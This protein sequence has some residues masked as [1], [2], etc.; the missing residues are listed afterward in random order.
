MQKEK[1]EESEWTPGKELVHWIPDRQLPGDLLLEEFDWKDVVRLAAAFPVLWEHLEHMVEVAYR[2][3]LPDPDAI[4]NV[5][6]R[7]RVSLMT[8]VG[9][10]DRN[11]YMDVFHKCAADGDHKTAEWLADRLQITGA[12]IRILFG[13]NVFYAVCCSGNLSLVQWFADRF[14]VEY[15]DCFNKG[16]EGVRHPFALRRACEHGHIHVA[17]WLVDRFG[18][19]GTDVRSAR[20]TVA[21][22]ICENGQLEVL[23]WLI[24]R[25]DL[26]RHDVVEDN[27]TFLKACEHG[28]LRLAKWMAE[29]YNMTREEVSRYDEKPLQLACANGHTAMV[30]WLCKTYG[31]RRNYGLLQKK[32]GMVADVPGGADQRL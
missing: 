16:P 17:E 8:S 24:Y 20:N 22:S 32:G 13:N 1:M 19:N 26:S 28:H 9:P 11:K 4:C 23:Q 5:P 3:Y 31:F 14:E 30:K 29:E 2:Y 7:L 21:W 27:Y 18:I 12:D 25:F 10:E 15:C 6:G